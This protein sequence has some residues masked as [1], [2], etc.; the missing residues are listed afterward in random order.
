M[1]IKLEDDMPFISCAKADNG[2]YTIYG[3]SNN[4]LKEHCTQLAKSTVSSTLLNTPANFC[5]NT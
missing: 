4:F 1:I 5:I 2:V 3:T